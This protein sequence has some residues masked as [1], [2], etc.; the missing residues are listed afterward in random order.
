MSTVVPM[1]EYCVPKITVV[2]LV[3]EC[4]DKFLSEFACEFEAHM[5]DVLRHGLNGDGGLADEIEYWHTVCS[6]DADDPE[7]SGD[8]WDIAEL[9]PWRFED[10]P[11]VAVARVVG[12]H[13]KG[14]KPADFQ[15]YGTTRRARAEQDA[16]MAKWAESLGIELG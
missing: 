5:K 14:W 6:I 16:I 9:G 12:R 13:T 8:R 4:A 1:I 10:V 11:L 15:A 7:N 3:T 2:D